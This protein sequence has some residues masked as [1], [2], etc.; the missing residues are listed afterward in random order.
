MKECCNNCIFSTH[1]IIGK[2]KDDVVLCQ[3]YPPSFFIDT[4]W[5]EIFDPTVDWCGEYKENK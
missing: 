3:R 4:G 1:N 2:S 5:P